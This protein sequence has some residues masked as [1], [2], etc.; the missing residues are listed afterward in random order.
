MVGF[1]RVAVL[2][3]H[4]QPTGS[5]N[6]ARW[7]VSGVATAVAA[8]LCHA[9]GVAPPRVWARFMWVVGYRPGESCGGRPAAG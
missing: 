6:A 2:D 5:V 4:P 7:L 3:E 1:E 9:V 8:T